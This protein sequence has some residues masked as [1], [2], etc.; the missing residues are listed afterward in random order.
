MASRLRIDRWPRGLALAAWTR[1]LMPSI[2]PLA[3]LLSNQRRMPWQWRLT[4]PDL[5][6]RFELVVDSSEIPRLQECGR[7]RTGRLLIEFL[8]GKPD[9]KGERDS[10]MMGRE[11]VES[12]LPPLRQV[13]GISQPDVARTAQRRLALLF[14][15]AH[16]IDRLVDDLDV[17]ELVDGD[18][19]FGR[20]SA[21]PLMK[22]ELMSMQTSPIASGAPRWAVRS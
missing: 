6:Y 10:Q 18:R 11:P 7:C 17:T 4:V 20:L 5:D 12:G 19:G 1:L 14:G 2:N 8:E 9:L 15:A 3:I 16:L 13:G 22:A 21:T